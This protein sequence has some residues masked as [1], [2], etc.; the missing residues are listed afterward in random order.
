MTGKPTALFPEILASLPVT[1]A[2]LTIIED[3]RQRLDD[4]H[5]LWETYDRSDAA[6]RRGIR[7]QIDAHRQRDSEALHE[8]I[9]LFDL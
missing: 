1:D 9:R 8:L 7:H 2:V 4:V 5:R 3:A 6:T